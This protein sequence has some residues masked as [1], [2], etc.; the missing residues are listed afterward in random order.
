MRARI[1]R[2]DDAAASE[3][4]FALVAALT[5]AA[6]FALFAYTVLAAD[7]GATAG[8]SAQF[9]R[10]RLE[11][12]ADAGLATAVEGLGRPPGQRWAIDGR[13][14]TFTL[15]GVEIEATVEDERGKVPLN[16]IK[17]DQAR[18]LFNAAGVSGAR[19]DQLTDGL[20]SWEDGVDRPN[21]ARGIDYAA[22]GVRRRAGPVRTLG[23]LAA[24]K[25]MDPNI[26]ARI[27]P[28]VTLFPADSGGFD[29]QTASPLAL[30]VMSAG[31]ADSPG[32]I[33]RARALAGERAALDTGPST[34]YVGRTLTIRIAARD[35]GG[36]VFR[37]TTVVELTGQPAHPFWVRAID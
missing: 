27:A 10:A 13:T 5:G 36:G 25:G 18:R 1:S 7:R 28:A 17:P 30:K 19:L 37:R 9:Q 11:A 32:A 24:I 6:L 8:L 12:A 22:D 29:S 23:E 3:D 14:L 15:D 31:G 4:G 34:T 16:G 21:G 33:I 2:Q 35:S 26:L 20:L